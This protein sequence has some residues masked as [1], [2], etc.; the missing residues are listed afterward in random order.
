M[1]K[2]RLLPVS[3][4]IVTV[5]FGENLSMIF[6]ITAYDDEDAVSLVMHNLRAIGAN[7]YG[8]YHVECEEI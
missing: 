4:F 8:T 6:R 2:K 5:Y 7:L 1:V 3:R